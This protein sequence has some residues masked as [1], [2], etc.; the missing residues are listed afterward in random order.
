MTNLDIL[1]ISNVFSFQI[2]AFQ[3]YFDSELTPD[4]KYFIILP[5]A[6]LFNF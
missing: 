6:P 4:S 5:K 1:Q 3:G 2:V